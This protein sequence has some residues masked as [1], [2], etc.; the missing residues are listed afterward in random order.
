MLWT[1]AQKLLRSDDRGET[2]RERSPDLST[3]NATKIAGEGHIRYCTITTHAESH[4]Q[5]GLVWAGTDDG[6]V[7]STPN[8]GESWSEHTQALAAAGA[9][10][11]RWTSRVV[12]SRHSKDRAYV[13]KSGYRRDDFVPYLYVTDDGGATWR[14]IT[15]LQGEAASLPE[16]PISVVLEDPTNP[17][18]LFVGNDFGVWA[19]LDRGLRWFRLSTQLPTAPV[20]DLAIQER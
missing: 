11:D 4:L 1:G 12:P 17:N 16:A 6:R 18:L 8:G 13:A 3:N 7:W 10:I 19:S 14:S 2:W 15:G 9:P 5:Q 20:R